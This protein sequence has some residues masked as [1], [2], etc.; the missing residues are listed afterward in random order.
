MIETQLSKGLTLVA[1]AP[2]SNVL[3][4][5]PAAPA[6]P[7]DLA[8]G[9]RNLMHEEFSHFLGDVERRLGQTREIERSMSGTVTGERRVH[10]ED[11]NVNLH[12]IDGYTMTANTPAAGSI[13][14]T[15]VHIV[16]A[17]VDY[18]IADGNTPNRYAWFVKPA[19]GTTATLQTGNTKPTLGPNDCLVF[20]NNVGTPV[21]ALTS[22]IPV[23]VVDGAIDS[24]AIANGAVT[25]AKTDFYTSLNTAIT[26]AQ[27]KADAAMAQA[28]GSVTTYFQAAPPWA[29]GDAT[30]G[31]ATNPAAKVGD[32]WYDSDDGQGYRW[33]G[34]AGSPANTWVLI[35]DT[36]ITTAL[37]N[38]NAAQTTANSKITTFYAAQAAVP[39][40]TSVGDMWVVTDLGN[41]LRR[42]SATGTASW[43]TVQI[44]GSAIANGGV[45]NTQLGSGIDGAKLVAASVTSTQ[46]GDSAIS[47]SKLNIL[48]HVMF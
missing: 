11:L 28:D 41:Q 6:I 36:A 17:G 26:N 37:A 18:T 44:S 20:F 42:A 7:D 5:E 34:A 1:D 13:A 24:G 46:I 3:E 14:W 40:A 12:F 47:P 25:A 21:N 27:T 10:T 23:A 8:Q 45:G 16:F 22:T 4:A 15:A 48:Q 29:T 19:S 30:A 2:V 32:L 35:K 38:A 9:I 31:G 39:T 33:S 43:V